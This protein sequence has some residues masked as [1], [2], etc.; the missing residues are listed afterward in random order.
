LTDPASSERDGAMT[1][2]P[3]HKPRYHRPP[4]WGIHDASG[5]RYPGGDGPTWWEDARPADP[6]WRVRCEGSPA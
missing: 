3:E 2:T 6:G 1:D 5:V 4:S